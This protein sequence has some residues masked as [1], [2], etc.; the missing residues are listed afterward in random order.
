MKGLFAGLALALLACSASDDVYRG[1]RAECEFGGTLTD[2][3]D[4][5]RDVQSACWRLVDCGAIPVHHETD[6]NRLDWDNCVNRLETRTEDRRRVTIACIAS[7][8][9][10]ELRSG[11]C[12]N[13]GDF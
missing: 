7:S 13:L 1:S 5:E 12:L 8:A 2:C 6:E 10:D 9:C 3:P 4:A 11:R